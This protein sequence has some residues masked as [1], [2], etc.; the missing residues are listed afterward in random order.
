MCGSVCVCFYERC[1]PPIAVANVG[2]GLSLFSI[3]YSHFG[4]LTLLWIYVGYIAFI[5]LNTIAYALLRRICKKVDKRDR[6]A[7][8]M[9]KTKEA[10]TIKESDGDQKERKRA[11]PDSCVRWLVT[12]GFF[13]ITLLIVCVLIVLIVLPVQFLTPLIEN[14]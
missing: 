3:L 2:L 12:T 14:N 5:A 11:S 4:D 9:D 8:K 7:V 1:L 6:F 13:I 10:V